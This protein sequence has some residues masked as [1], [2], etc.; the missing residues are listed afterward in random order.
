MHY[1]SY[2]RVIITIT[3]TTIRIYQQVTNQ[4]HDL[5]LI[6]STTA[7][8]TTTAIQ[9]KMNEIIVN[10]SNFYRLNQ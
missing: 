1:Y 2:S 7:T 9:M 3:I 8:I 4:S 5:H 6:H 10:T